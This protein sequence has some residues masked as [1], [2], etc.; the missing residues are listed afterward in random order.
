MSTQVAP[1]PKYDCVVPDEF[2][3][4]GWSAAQRDQWRNEKT[5]GV[6][7]RNRYCVTTNKDIN[8]DDYSIEGLY[9]KFEVKAGIPVSA[10]WKMPYLL[11]AARA[12]RRVGRQRVAMEMVKVERAVRKAYNAVKLAREMLFTI[13]EGRSF[14]NKA[15]KKV[16]K[17]LDSD[18][19]DATMADKF[20]LKIL[21]AEVDTWELEAKKM[22]STALAGLRALTGE[23]RSGGRI[24]LDVDSKPLEP[25]ALALKTG[26]HY[27]RLARRNRPELKAMN[28]AVAAARA[29]VKLRWA[30]FWPDL[31]LAVRYSYTYSNSDD[32]VSAYARDS[33]HGNSIFVGLV[34]KFDLDFH[35]K[36]A[37]Y[38]EAKAARTAAAR[39]RRA[40]RQKVRYEVKRAR[41]AVSSSTKK[42]RLARTGHQAAK[43]WLTAVSQQHDM[44]TARAKE[45][46]DA[47]KAYFKTK[48][49]VV[50]AVYEHNM[51]VAGLRASVGVIGR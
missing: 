21:K 11:R 48:I 43:S 29:A 24:P 34:F 1:T 27:E 22:E 20:R 9:F 16:E 35:L 25:V 19:G 40:M 37:K 32:P 8:V 39:G 5:D 45:V 51:A 36:R 10:F 28:A 13:D 50:K 33:L 47:L 7:N 6:A 31:A 14:L 41:Q 44:G 46:A 38:M 23:P 26:D 12:S 18:D 15:I 42:I 49:A 4:S 2:L 3:P 17:D 30:S